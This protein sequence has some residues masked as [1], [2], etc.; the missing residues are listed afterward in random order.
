MTN[1]LLKLLHS[2]IFLLISLQL[3][4]G[5]RVVKCQKGEA[6]LSEVNFLQEYVRLEGEW[7]F[8]Y[9]ELLTPD[10]LDSISADSF[11]QIPEFWKHY[12]GELSKFGC[13]T[14]K[15]TFTLNKSQL[16]IPLSIRS[17]NIH[18]AYKVWFNG[19]VIT[20]VG[21]VG[22]SF[23][24]SVPRWLPLN[25]DLVELQL[26][27]ELVIQVSNYRHRNGGIQDAI[28]IGLSSQFQ[29]DYRHQYFS[30][31]FLS[32]AAFIL[33]CFFI[34]MFFFWKKDRAALDFG[35]FSVFFS[36]RIMMV[37]T[38][39]I[40]FTFEDLPWDVLIRFEYISMFAMHYFMFSFVYHA[41][42]M[43]TS[44]R[45]G[46]ILKLV[47]IVLVII[48]IIPGDFFTYTTIPNNYYLLVTFIYCVIIFIKGMKANVPGA[49]WAVLAMAIF[50]VTTIPMILEYSNLFITDPVY[51][52]IS[53][54]GFM[55]SMS[56]VFASRFGFAFSFLENLKNSEEL[57]K[58]EIL[59]QK[60]KL[61]RS[62]ALIS[63]SMNYAQGIQQS[64]LP[65]DNDLRNNF[66]E[67]FV[68]FKPTG[69][70][71]GDFYWTKRR[72]DGKEALI[73]VADCTGHGVPGAFI[74]LIAISAL[75]NLVE[76][77]S[78]VET[79][80]LLAELND[81]IHDRLSKSFEKGRV[82]KEG[83]DIGICKV[84]F[85]E[86]KVCFS[87]AHHKM[88]LIR[89]S[90][91][92]FIYQGENHHLGMPLS[93]DFEFKNFEVNLEDGDQIYLFTDGVYDQKGGDEGKK[94]YLKRLIDEILKNRDLAAHRQKIEFEEFMTEWMGGK[95][96]MDDLLL[97]GMR[98]KK[99]DPNLD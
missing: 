45:Y 74:S 28:E 64:L 84:N 27:N 25:V 66:G 35:I 21:I 97:F 96:Q 9:N 41:F 63:E 42:R 14:Y 19:K 82:I 98:Y 54:I 43:Q 16:D 71:S 39:S 38:R 24:N 86:H 13:A 81:L 94:L 59:R 10:Q 80:L 37:G 8:F 56:L 18:N 3:F 92:Y 77:K 67:C 76:R 23:E 60:D 12:D 95:E 89:N 65:S 2:L 78:H 48:S 69:K 52:N 34:G 32:G 50:F 4:A 17:A 57:Q 47:T 26:R 33:G 91:E 90:G 30:E 70:V 20:E 72:K 29:A 44:K 46:Q 7:E 15:L 73:S 88:L 49:I 93:F 87:A 58:Q 36:F 68:F 40:G 62:N 22:T 79:N 6:N 75:D 83:L 55:L 31:V 53:Y 11:G 99:S 85:E 1:Y 61:E 5:Y 51:L